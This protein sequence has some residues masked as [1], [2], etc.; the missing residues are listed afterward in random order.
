ML[1]ARDRTETTSRVWLGLTANCAV[2]HD[3]KFDPLSQREFYK[4]AAFFNNTTQGGLDGNVKDTPPTEVIP[5]AADRA[6][7]AAIGPSLARASQERDAR[8]KT[9][10]TDFEKWAAAATVDSIG[11][12]VPKSQLHL[13]APLDRVHAGTTSLQVDGQER[14]VKLRPSASWQAGPVP[15]RRSLLA[16]GTACELSDVGDFDTTNPSP[17]PP[18][19][20]F[21]STTVTVLISRP[22]GEPAAIP[23]L[24][25]VG[26]T[27]ADRHAHHPLVARRGAQSRRQLRVRANERAHVAVR[28]TVGKAARGA[29][30]DDGREQPTEVEAT[31]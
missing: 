2:C 28:T 3:H 6:R 10:R 17:A 26:R 5:K 27:T 31:D 14:Q 13:S 4:L 7:W 18:G 23:R 9:A 24:G 20:G 11:G 8:R 1:Y 15:N 25:H 16:Q 30:Y 12:A 29:R 19:S 22:D 21:P